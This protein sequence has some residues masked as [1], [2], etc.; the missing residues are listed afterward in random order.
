M[1]GAR[2]RAALQESR[3]AVCQQLKDWDDN[4]LNSI[5]LS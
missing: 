2:Q 4:T 3:Q 5:N 1:A